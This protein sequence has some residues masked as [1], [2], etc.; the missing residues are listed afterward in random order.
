MIDNRGEFCWRASREEN[1]KATFCAQTGIF[2]AIGIID[3]WQLQQAATLVSGR[4]CHRSL[5]GC[6]QVSRN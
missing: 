5:S 2:Q 4:K 6:I 3:S 1:P